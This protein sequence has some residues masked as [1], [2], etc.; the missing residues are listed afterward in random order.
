[1]AGNGASFEIRNEI[2]IPQRDGMTSSASPVGTLRKEPAQIVPLQQRP[3]QG[4]PQPTET[5]D[6]T[7]PTSAL[8]NNLLRKVQRQTS[9]I[10]EQNR[11][12]MDH[13]Q[14]RQLV[15]T[16]QTPFPV[17]S[18]RGRS[19]RQSR[20]RSLRHS[21]RVMSLSY[22]RRSTR[23]RSPR[24]S[25]PRR[26]PLRRSPPRRSP[27]RGS[28]PRR[29]KRSWLSSSSEDTRDARNDRNAYGPFTRRI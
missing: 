16:K 3:L 13:E 1:M 28:P 7:T 20:F 29:N 6:D 27:P 23:R 2:R 8:V 24:R 21:V 19:P 4:P 5:P 9:L 17:R 10:D 15:R 14:T 22:T 11:R 25:P 12:L 26:S 18:S